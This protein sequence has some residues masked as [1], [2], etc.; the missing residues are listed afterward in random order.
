MASANQNASNFVK[1]TAHFE[2]CSIEAVTALLECINLD[3][4][5]ESI[6]HD[7]LTFHACSYNKYCC[8][9]LAIEVQCSVNS[10]QPIFS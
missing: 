3:A 5:H 8:I 6:F 10:F 7:F 4:K 1:I 2:Y 9:H